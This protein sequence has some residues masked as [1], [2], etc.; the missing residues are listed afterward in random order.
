RLRREPAGDLAH[1]REQ[2]QRTVVR[3]D[4]LVGHAGRAALGERAGQLFARGE[5]QVGEQD[6][7][8]PEQLVLGGQRLLDLQEEVGLAPDLVG[9]AELCADRLVVVVVERAAAAGT[10]L[11]EHFM[12]ALDELPR[13]R[14]GERD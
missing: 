1:R 8:L 6:E 11:D 3:L 13:T 2:W 10:G 4:G 12:A 7:A 5:M 9:G 14:W